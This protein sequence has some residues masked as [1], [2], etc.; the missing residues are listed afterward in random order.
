MGCLLLTG[1]RLHFFAGAGAADLPLGSRGSRTDGGV[2][3]QSRLWVGNA[4]HVVGHGGGQ[5]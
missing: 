4:V 5:R 2:T 1:R 3:H